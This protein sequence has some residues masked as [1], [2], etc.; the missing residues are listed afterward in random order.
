MLCFVM[1][2]VI[3]QCAIIGYPFYGTGGAE[4]T[5]VTAT[6]MD[7]VLKTAVTTITPRGTSK[8]TRILSVVGNSDAPG[9]GSRIRVSVGNDAITRYYFDVFP[10]LDG[11][12]VTQPIMMV[13]MNDLGGYGVNENENITILLIDPGAAEKMSGVLYLE[14]DEPAYSMPVGGRPVTLKFGLTTDAST[15]ISTT[16]GDVPSTKLEDSYN[17]AVI[18][19]I[20]RPEDKVCQANIFMDGNGRS[21]TAAPAGR[22][23][24]PHPAFVFTG[25]QWNAGTI[26]NY[27]QVEAATVVETILLLLEFPGSKVTGT[28]KPIDTQPVSF[29]GQPTVPGAGAGGNSLNMNNQPSTGMGFNLFGG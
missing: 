7:P 28:E 17:Y 9:L 20:T 3:N 1:V 14:D 15:T 2:L 26:K 21:Y 29:P 23:L 27:L 11:D 10:G 18:G 4:A 22:I 19:S 8:K 12:L 13:G 25:A 6:V 16:G 24:L 5:P